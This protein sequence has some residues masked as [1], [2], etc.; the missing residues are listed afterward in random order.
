MFCTGEREKTPEGGC[1]PCIQT[2]RRRKGL[3]ACCH[4][5]PSRDLDLRGGSGQ[6]EVGARSVSANLSGG[7]IARSTTYVFGDLPYSAR[8]ERHIQ[9]GQE[10]EDSEELDSSKSSVCLP[11]LF[12]SSLRVR[13]ALRAS[14]KGATN[15]ICKESDVRNNDRHW[16]RQT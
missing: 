9:Q 14:C 16:H 6:A 5:P 8:D 12:L 15:A 7:M 10:L 1:E 11:V 4:R 2:S 13:R 3:H